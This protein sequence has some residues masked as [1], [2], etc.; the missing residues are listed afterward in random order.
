MKRKCFISEIIYPKKYTINVF[1]VRFLLNMLNMRCKI[2]GSG[3]VVGLRPIARMLD[4]GRRGVPSVG[5]G[6]KL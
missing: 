1:I 4:L 6:D 5:V 3:W 2:V